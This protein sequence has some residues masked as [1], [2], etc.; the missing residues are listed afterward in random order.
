MT[1]TNTDRHRPTPT[2]H[3]PRRGSSASHRCHVSTQNSARRT[4]SS[5]RQTR[6]VRSAWTRSP[7][8]G[9]TRHPQLRGF[10]AAARAL[11]GKQHTSFSPALVGEDLCVLP[12]QTTAMGGHRGPHPTGEALGAIQRR[13]QNSER[14]T[15]SSARRTQNSVLR[16]AEL[17]SSAT[18]PRQ[19]HPNGGCRT[20]SPA[21]TIVL[22]YAH[23][24]G[25]VVDGRSG[26]C[27][28]PSSPAFSRGRS[29]SSW[30]S[31]C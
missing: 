19:N 30:W 1:R 7:R 17:R 15:P 2:T 16:H 8:S 27:I 21:G 13:T 10:A 24:S 28:H 4:L 14:S 23:A 22:S 3:P 26:S 12:H 5:G 9:R 6:K 29:R 18:S 25:V 31:A 20:Q 11:Q